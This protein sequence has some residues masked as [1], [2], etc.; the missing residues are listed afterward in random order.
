MVEAITGSWV[1]IFAVIAIFAVVVGL[2]FKGQDKG[3]IEARG[4]FGVAA[5]FAAVALVAAMGWIPGLDI[6]TTA[7]YQPGTPGT[8]GI[9]EEADI[10]IIVTDDAPRII[11]SLSIRT[12]EESSG[13]KDQCGG[14]VLYFDSSEDPRLSTAYS[15][16]TTTIASGI[17]T[18]TS[19]QVETNTLYHIVFTN[20]SSPPTHYD[21]VLGAKVW[22][23][24]DSLTPI[25][26]K[27]PAT[28]DAEVSAIIKFGEDGTARLGKI[29]T[30]PDMLDETSTDG[31]INGE[32]SAIA[33]CTTYNGTSGLCEAYSAS[34]ITVGP[35]TGSGAGTATDDQTVYYNDTNGD[36]SFY[37]RLTFGADG[38]QAYLKRPVLC[39]VNDMSSP[40][41]RNEFTSITAS[42]YTGSGSEV[43]L[44][45]D[46]LPS[47]NN[48]DACVEIGGQNIDGVA[49]IESGKTATYTLTFTV[50]EDYTDG[51]NDKFYMIADD[52]GNYLGQDIRQGQGA[53]VTGKYVTMSFMA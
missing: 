25:T 30:I 3:A 20:S 6:Q 16:D 51:S 40:C 14:S 36:G 23:P 34:E 24:S 19:G 9:P 10:A 43:V 5:I 1:T 45:S 46:L 29:A 35:A 52:L 33:T 49:I 13:K 37:L 17:G 32:T 8:P 22:N 41:E 48:M 39:F 4:M 38:S 21:G 47:F 7:P 15:I 50:D 12:T 18:D 44:P 11:D 31:R 28:T 2:Y 53:A 27:A 26:I 42:L